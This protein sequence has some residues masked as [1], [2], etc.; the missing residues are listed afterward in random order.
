MRRVLLVL[1][2][3]ALGVFGCAQ[4]LTDTRLTYDT[5]ILDTTQ[6]PLPLPIAIEFLSPDDPNRFFILEKWTGKVKLVE[7][8]VVVSTVL[9]LPVNTANWERGLLYIVL[10][11]DFDR[12]GYVYLFYSRDSTGTDTSDAANWAENRLERYRWNG[13]TLTDPST[14]LSIPFD[15]NLANGPIHNG[16]VM[17]FGPDGMLWL[18]VGDLNRTNGIET[19]RSQT[20]VISGAGI[21]RIRDDGT[22]PPDNPFISHSD[23][24][25][26]RLW[27]YGIRN[28]FGMTIDSLTNNLWITENGPNQYD[29]INLVRRGFNSAWYRW[30]GPRNRAN[31]NLNSL[32]WL[33][34]AYYDDPKFSWLTPIGVSAITFLR[35]ARFP[36]D[37]RDH[38]I[39]GESNNRRLYRFPMNATR[40]RFDFSAFPE[41]QDLV[42]DTADERNLLSWGERWQIVSDLKVGPDGFLYVVT[43]IGSSTVRPGVRRI[44][45]VN[46][47]EILNGKVALQ[48]RHGLPLGVPLT[49]KLYNGD[50][51]V[52]TIH[53]TLD[54]YGKF[55][56][57]VSAPGTYTLKAKAGSYLSVS[58]PNVAIAPQGFAYRALA[59]TVNGDVNGDDVIDD[60]DLLAVLFAFGSS[61]STADL[62][63]DGVVDDA[64]LLT[65]LFNFGSHGE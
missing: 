25:I 35:S 62:N 43:H 46:P 37:I 54:A 23:N 2:G 41:L 65:V 16:G 6:N 64:D 52:Q 10:H 39:V 3:T 40:D 17:F 42:A 32:V 48:G 8:G 55:S 30:M 15:S 44:R 19:N 57:Q 12:N 26:R 22:I 45:P 28:S 4:T 7:N 53:T 24:R 11:P 18:V 1:I 13:S 14:I 20:L 50:T 29:E 56:E 34:N 21:I 31:G 47:P 60:A 27:A 59:F 9:D 36:Q 49:L 58:V 61:D 63:N 33:P 38:A 51:L 5:V